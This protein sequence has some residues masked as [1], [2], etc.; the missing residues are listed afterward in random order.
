M[1]LVSGDE[2][3]AARMAKQFRAPDYY[4]YDDY[5]LCLNHPQVDAVFIATPALLWMAGDDDDGAAAVGNSP[6]A[7]A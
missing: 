7:A 6:R 1:A 3:K 2:R 4:T 5:A